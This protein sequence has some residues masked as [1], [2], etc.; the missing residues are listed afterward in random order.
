MAKRGNHYELAFENYLRTLR[1]PCIGVDESRRAFDGDDTLKSLDLIVAA[2]SGLTLLVDIKGRRNRGVKAGF[3]N[4]TTADDMESMSR[5]QD[6][7]GDTALALLTFVY[8]LASEEAKE[9]FTNHFSL[10]DRHYA[11]VAIPLLDYRNHMRVR[12]SRWQTFTMPRALFRE[13][14]RP[15]TAWL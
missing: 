14:A 12:S 7:F 13:R 1:V 11:C 4:W 5:W 3:E 15:F 8:W 10:A 9:S 6:I 2:P